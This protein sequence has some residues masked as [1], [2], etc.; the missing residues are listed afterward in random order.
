MFVN[1]TG[2]TGKEV[3]WEEI[4]WWGSGISQPKVLPLV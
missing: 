3:A 2:Y 1:I 4:R